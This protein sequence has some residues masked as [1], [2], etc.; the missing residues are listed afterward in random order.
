MNI[1][2]DAFISVVFNKTDSGPKSVLIFRVTKH[3]NGEFRLF[4][5]K[6]YTT[7]FLI[8]L[9]ENC[10]YSYYECIVFQHYIININN[11]C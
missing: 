8:L 7:N 11:V 2:A 10:I 9:R 3:F 1:I 5:Y 4:Y 6:H